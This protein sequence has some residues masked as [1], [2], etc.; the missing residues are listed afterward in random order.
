[1]R[2][3]FSK[4]YEKEISNVIELEILIPEKEVNSYMGTFVFVKLIIIFFMAANA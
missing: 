1:M 3:Y 4:I 2:F